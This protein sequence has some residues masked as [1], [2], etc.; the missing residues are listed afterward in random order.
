MKKKFPLEI[1]CAEGV[2]FQEEVESVYL[3]GDEG[4][5][6]LLPFHYPLVASLASS[7]INIAGYDPVPIQSGVV[8]FNNNVW[9][10]NWSNAW[11]LQ[12]MN[13]D[14]S[15]VSYTLIAS[16]GAIASAMVGSIFSSDAWNGV[17]FMAGEITNPKKNIVI[18]NC[19][20]IL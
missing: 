9:H 5:F 8:M 7:K 6:E 15:I 14:G 18:N 19:V 16:F 20:L 17:T 3:F 1:V 13:T 12:R 10:S 11:A 2:L 4:E